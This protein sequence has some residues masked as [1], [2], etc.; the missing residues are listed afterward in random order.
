[1]LKPVI[2]YKALFSL[3][4]R[5][6]GKAV[7]TPF[8]IQL[9]GPVRDDGRLMPGAPVVLWLSTNAVQLTGL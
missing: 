7:N 4:I 3:S 2:V 5:A 8:A 9:T 1:M 6:I